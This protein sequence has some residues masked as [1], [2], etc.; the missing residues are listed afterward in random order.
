MFEYQSTFTAFQYFDIDKAN[1]H[2]LDFIPFNYYENWAQQVLVPDLMSQKPNIYKPL[3]D[4]P[5]D[6]ESKKRVHLI[7]VGMSKMGVAMA[8]EAAQVAHFPNFSSRG[9]RTLITFIDRNAAREMTF[10]K[11]RFSNLFEISRHRY[12]DAN[13]LPSGGYTVEHFYDA[14]PSSPVSKT[15]KWLDPMNDVD[16]TSRFKGRESWRQNCRH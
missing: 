9:V 2:L 6:S 14:N 5:I 16:S 13:Q 10:F 12:V 3:Y 4:T 15:H 7:I 11:G 8:I 1:C